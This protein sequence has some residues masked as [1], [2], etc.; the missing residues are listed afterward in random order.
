MSSHRASAVQLR[1]RY[2]RTL[3]LALILS[4]LLHLGMIHLLSH[5]AL[6]PGKRTAKDFA[7][8]IKVEDIPSTAQVRIMP[9]PP[10]PFVPIPDEA[11]AFPADVEITPVLLDWTVL[12]EPPEP[13]PPK[14]RIE[15]EFAFVPYEQP[16]EPIGGL[17]SFYK[18]VRYPAAALRSHVEG[19]VIVGIL[20][21]AE[22]NTLKIQ[23]LKGSGTDVG[24]ERAALNAVEAIRWKP[25]RQR[26]R[27]VKVWLALPVRFQLKYVNWVDAGF[28][29]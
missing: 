21:D 18:V 15:D 16:P 7:L 4:L 22:G 10:L 17:A 29:R 11:E 20:I 6:K 26:D 19:M 5:S 27:A 25:A 9:P 3:E 14:K 24:F 13:P 28:D 2:R 1:V 23:L 8:K 12:P